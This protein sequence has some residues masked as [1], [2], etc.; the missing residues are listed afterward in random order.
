MSRWIVVVLMSLM[1]ASVAHASDSEEITDSL[2]HRIVVANTEN[3][4]GA[5]ETNILLRKLAR[6][7][8]FALR[9]KHGR[10]Q[11]PHC[12]KGYS[13]GEFEQIVA[14][15]EKRLNEVK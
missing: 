4:L 11:C 12:E 2:R 14:D 13:E 7:E 15:V 8:N 5:A 9:I 3:Q 6:A 1:F 10:N